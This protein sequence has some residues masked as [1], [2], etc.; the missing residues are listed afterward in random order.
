MLNKVE[1]E[2]SFDAE[3][4]FVC[5]AIHSRLDANDVLVLGQNINGAAYAAVGADGASFFNLAGQ[6][7]RTHRLLVA[8]RAGWAGLNTLSTEGTRGLLSESR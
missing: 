8:K 2:L 5:R 1:C 3:R 7:N 4:S 6:F